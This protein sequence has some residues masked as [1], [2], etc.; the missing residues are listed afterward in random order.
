MLLFGMTGSIAVG[1][2]TTAA[3]FVQA[4]MFHYDADAAVHAL[5]A[6]GGAAVAPLTG[7][8]PEAISDG[9]VDR[10]RLSALLKESPER[11]KEL[12]VIVHPLASAHQQD[13]L[14]R[15]EID[16][17]DRALL[18][19]P[20]LFET[21]SHTRVDAIAVVT[22]SA[23]IQRSRALERPD[24]AEEKLAMI[25]SRQ[26]PDA[27]KRAHAD[28]LVDTGAGMDNARAQVGRIA[29]ALNDWPCRAWRERRES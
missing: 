23:D 12:E 29:A 20:L 19:I 21:R 3:M 8:F 17:F 24:M 22:C 7:A 1:K 27:E 11:L 5:Y 4:D 15:A 9:S 25:L 6:P 26:M 10:A 28:F 13:A 14:I 2:S 16:G 18:D